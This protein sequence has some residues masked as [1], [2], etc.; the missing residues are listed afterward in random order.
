MI[1]MPKGFECLACGKHHDFDAYV[2]AHW[3]E[4]LIHTCD[5]GAKHDI[6]RGIV[7]LQKTTRQP[8]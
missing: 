1:D 8:K 7:I 2:F 6:Q 3:N 4:S 5:C